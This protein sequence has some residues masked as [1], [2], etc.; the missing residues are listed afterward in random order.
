MSVL[1]RGRET[2]ALRHSA[3]QGKVCFRCHWQTEHVVLT[4]SIFSLQQQVAQRSTYQ[5]MKWCCFD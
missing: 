4:Q 2:A 1:A 5:E 3:Q